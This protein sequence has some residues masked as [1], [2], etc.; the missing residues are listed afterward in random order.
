[1]MFISLIHFIILLSC[2]YLYETRLDQS[3]CPYPQ[4]EVASAF[5]LLS[6]SLSKGL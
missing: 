6:F 3:Q 5:P 1:M 2:K 4:G